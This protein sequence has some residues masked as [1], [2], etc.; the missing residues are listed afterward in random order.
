MKVDKK[1]TV[2]DML[3]LLRDHYEGTDLDLTQGI[4]AGPFGDPDRYDARPVNGLQ[5]EELKGHMFPRAISM[6]RTLYFHIQRSHA[7]LP[8]EVRKPK[9]TS[10]E[11]HSHCRRG[12]LIKLSLLNACWS[13]SVRSRP[14]PFLSSYSAWLRVQVNARILVGHHEPSDTVVAPL[15]VFADMV[16]PELS[17]GSLFAYNKKSLYWSSVLLGNWVHKYYIIASA[18]VRPRIDAFESGLFQTMVRPPNTL[19][20]DATMSALPSTVTKMAG[21][22][23]YI[24]KVDVATVRTQRDKSGKSVR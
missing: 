4:A 23:C 1:I 10:R 15:Y 21:E 3:R 6:F 24:P 8:K 13:Y 20:S 7:D 2:E 16:P 14:A 12:L 9:R 19:S 17:T 5:E 18:F 22:R 11:C